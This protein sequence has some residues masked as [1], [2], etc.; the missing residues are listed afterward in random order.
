MSVKL[1]RHLHFRLVVS[2][3]TPVKNENEKIKR[4]VASH[5]K[6]SIDRRSYMK[7]KTKCERTNKNQLQQ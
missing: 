6:G 5:G 7:H 4:N 1:T 3:L 2:K